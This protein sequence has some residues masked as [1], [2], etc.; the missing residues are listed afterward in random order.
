MISMN[1]KLTKSIKEDLSQSGSKVILETLLT[2]WVAKHGAEATVFR[3]M[4]HF[5]NNEL[6]D[7]S[8]FLSQSVHKFVSYIVF[9]VFVATVVL[10]YVSG[11]GSFDY[12]YPTTKEIALSQPSQAL[13]GFVDVFTLGCCSYKVG[14]FECVVS[15]RIRISF[16]EFNKFIFNVW[17]YST[18]NL[19]VWM[20]YVNSLYS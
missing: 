10:I 13:V 6:K 3:L 1:I 18:T 16:S 19:V 20:D 14:T 2:Y 9:F 5:E 12:F 15:F 11:N 17:E 7:L 4:E 8:Q